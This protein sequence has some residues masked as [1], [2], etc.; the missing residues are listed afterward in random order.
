MTLTTI[1]SK[2]DN[3]F[4]ETNLDNEKVIMDLE[5]G[6]YININP[7]GSVI[8]ELID[9]PISINAICEALTKMFEVE[10]SVCQEQTIIFLRK[11]SQKELLNFD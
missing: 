9:K 1:I 4:I 5:T 2:S 8:W 11:L 6:D 3:R 7:V 10:N